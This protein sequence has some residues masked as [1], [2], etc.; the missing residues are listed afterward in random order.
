MRHAKSFPGGEHEFGCAY[1]KTT[2]TD[3]PMGEDSHILN[4]MENLSMKD[5]F[6]EVAERVAQETAAKKPHRSRSKS[7]HK[8]D[9]ATHECTA[10][11][12]ENNHNKQR[13][14][15]SGH[16]EVGRAYSGKNDVTTVVNR[17][18]SRTDRVPSDE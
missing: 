6:R 7:S 2:P 18:P 15:V 4:G 1:L 3:L 5:K 8:N 13:R 14:S 17:M 10:V 11:Q 16:V 9:R 12:K